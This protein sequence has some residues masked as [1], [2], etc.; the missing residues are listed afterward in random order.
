MS[1]KSKRKSKRDNVESGP[2]TAETPSGARPVKRPAAPESRSILTRWWFYV[3]LL[4]VLGC[5][6]YWPA[7]SGTF[8][9]DDFDLME[10]ASAV[11][12]GGWGPIKRSGRPLL[13]LSFVGNLRAAGGFDPFWFH[14]TNI[15]LH[16][17]NA[18]LLFGFCRSLFR[19]E[20]V[21]ALVNEKLRPLFVYGLPLLFL[22]SPIQTESVAYVS[23][24][25]EVLAGTFY[26]LGL[27]AFVALR[28]RN[29]WAA[30]VAV[31][32]CFGLTALTKQDKLT[33]PFAVVMLDFLLLSRGDWR[34]LKKSWPLYGLFAVGI[35]VGFFVVVRPFLF[36]MS[37]GFTLDWREY[38]FTQFRMYFRY[39]AQLLFPFNLNLDPDISALGEPAR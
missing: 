23:S 18:A 7:T 38:L 4:F 22:L 25:S 30:A 10:S 13:M 36:T 11:R 5:V 39:M 16:C 26:I 9:L 2:A 28:D 8:V 35:V 31:M 6:V 14:L 33:L 32:F 12:N 15:L 24:R 34:G 17:L 37:A 29:R 21:S 20:S 27:W 1:V 19:H 3:A